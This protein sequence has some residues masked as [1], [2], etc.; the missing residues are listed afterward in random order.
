MDSEIIRQIP[1]FSNLH[2]NEIINM[3]KASKA[4]HC[5]PGEVVLR[6][7]DASDYFYILLEGEVEIIKSFGTSDERVL[8]ISKRGSILGEMSKFSQDGTHTATGRANTPCRL[9]RVPFAW[10]DSL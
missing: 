5:Q 6:E 9:L 4:Y 1:L 3:V 8:G 7:G 10:L 2:E